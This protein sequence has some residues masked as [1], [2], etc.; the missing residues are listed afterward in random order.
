MP[1]IWFFFLIKKKMSLFS[2]LKLS[3][4]QTLFISASQQQGYSF[5]FFCSQGPLRSITTLASTRRLY[6]RSFFALQVSGSFTPPPHSRDNRKLYDRHAHTGFSRQ[7][8]VE[9]KEPCTAFINLILSQVSLSLC[10]LVSEKFRQSASILL[11]LC[12]NRI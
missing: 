4:V 3:G 6:T 5:L 8:Y 12:F 10:L 2:I 11:D 1:K 9:Y 7:L